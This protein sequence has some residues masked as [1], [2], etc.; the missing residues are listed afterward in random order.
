[1]SNNQMEIDRSYT[2]LKN[3]WETVEL[4][5]YEKFELNEQIISF[6][7]QLIRLKE[8]FLRI[9]VFGKSGVGKSTILN[10][11]L[12]EKYFK[13][14]ILNGSTKK[15]QS[16][17]WV[18]NDGLINKI[19]LIDS[20]G[21]DACFNQKRDLLNVINLDL[22]LFVING[23]I[24][25]KELNIL[26][27]LIKKDKKVIIIFNKIDTWKNEEINIIIKNIKNKLPIESYTPI[28]KN[29]IKNNYP[30][31]EIISLKDYLL[32]TINRVGYQLIIYNTFQVTNKL[33]IDIKEKRLLRRKEQAQAIIGKFA[34]LKASSVAL[35]PLLF[36]DITG[37]LALDTFLIKELSNI[38]GL[39][40]KRNSAKQLMRAISWNN[41]FLGFTQIGINTTFN[42]IKKMSLIAAPFTSGISLLPYGPVAIA[43]AALA[44]R[45]TKI[46]G[47]LAAEEILKR[48]MINGFEPITLIKQISIK[49]LN[50]TDPKK[51]F[52]YNQNIMNDLSLFLP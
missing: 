31:K 39:K 4:S 45:N 48:S 52:L 34:L 5:N 13:T 27:N 32:S 36:I 46:T 50:I 2:I 41:L 47:K 49:E 15:I 40:I 29:S 37:S 44:V 9:G 23:D 42:V 25:R 19:E 28:F 24:N 14:G 7:Q 35:N 51:I 22:I 21:F 8:K 16:K 33:V 20:P 1:M 30:H 12:N 43:Q 17:E 11:I 18:F 10:S 38:Y 3:W 26:N 6:N